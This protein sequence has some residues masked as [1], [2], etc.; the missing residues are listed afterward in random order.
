MRWKAEGKRRTG[1]ADH[2]E[3][4]SVSRTQGEVK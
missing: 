4:S 2:V 3:Q 1:R